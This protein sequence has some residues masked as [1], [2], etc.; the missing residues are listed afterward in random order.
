MT[1]IDC[2]MSLLLF[3]SS[4]NDHLIKNTTMIKIL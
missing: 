2:L 3:D 1:T 4:D